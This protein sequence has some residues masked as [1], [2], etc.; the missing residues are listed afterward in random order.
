MSVALTDV[1][2]QIQDQ[3]RSIG[4][5]PESPRA[6][7]TADGA[8]TTFYLPL[9]PWLQYVA[10]SAQL[11]ATPIGGTPTGIASN[12]YTITQQGMVTF[13]LAPGADGSPTAVGSVI[14]AS[15]QATGFAD[16]DLTNVLTR[17]VVKYSSDDY[18]LKGCELDIINVLL[19]N[20]ERL[21][22]IREA[23]YE[24]NP[25]A[26][27]GALVKLKTLLA[28]EIEGSPRPGLNVPVLMTKRMGSDRPYQPVR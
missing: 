10:A 24:K 4:V 23:E 13:G 21:A 26:V 9:G 18:V 17:N 12:T 2:F 16:A 8:T 11:Y 14:G 25:A 22:A 5:S 19:A 27:I 3:P 15:F 28:T 1:R 20:T 6:L 7:G